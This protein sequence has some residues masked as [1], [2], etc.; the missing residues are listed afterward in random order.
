MGQ[1]RMQKEATSDDK[2][3]KFE[4][5]KKY[6]RLEAFILTHIPNTSEM[7]I[8]SRAFFYFPSTLYTW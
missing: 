6:K 3:D 7:K 2:R 5:V 8:K 1:E 4:N